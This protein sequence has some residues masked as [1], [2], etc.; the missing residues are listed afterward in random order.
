[1]ILY[2]GSYCAIEKPDLSFSRNRTDFGKGFYTTQFKEQAITWSERFIKEHGQGVVSMYDFDDTALNKSNILKFDSYSNEWF[3]FVVKCRRGF[4]D[5]RYDMV[6]GGVAN[7]RI[8]PTITLFLGEYISKEDALHR[9]SYEKPNQQYC[10]RS[11]TVIDE[12]LRYSNKEVF[13]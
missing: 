2:H 12:Y 7:D 8:F 5:T 6:I 3:D 11:Q 9:L 10:F 1:M 13:K 4:D